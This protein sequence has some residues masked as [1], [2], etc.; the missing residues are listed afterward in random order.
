MVLLVSL[1]ASARAEDGDTVEDWLDRMARAVE[2]LNYRGTLVHWRGEHLDTLRIIHRA[3]ESGIRER[4]Y[5]LNGEPREILRDGDRV[6]SLLAG[7]EPM[8]VQSQLTARLL[9]NLPLNRL[10]SARQAYEMRVRGTGRVAGLE[11]R[12]IEILPRDEYRYGHRFWLEQQTGML[13][14][15]ALLDQDGEAVQQL[16][17]VEI[18]L[19]ARISD[20]ELTPQI[21]ARVVLETRLEE[22]LPAVDHA[23]LPQRSWTPHWVPEHFHLTRQGQGMGDSGEPFEHLLYSDGLASFSVY[24]E[25]GLQGYEGSR[26]ES[27][28]SVHIYSGLLD[29]HQITIVGEVPLAAIRMLGRSLR[30]SPGAMRPR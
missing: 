8:V 28:G 24:I 17:F 5:S 1:M 3:D 21:D 6:R 12:I 18:E 2:T 13:L 30:R 14:R 26:I 23:E 16:S 19:G 22:N 11:T 27:I 29:G 25:E 10:R 4:L 15:S 20:R 9:P 7:Q